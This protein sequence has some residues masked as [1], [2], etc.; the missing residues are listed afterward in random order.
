MTTKPV[1]RAAA[2]ALALGSLGTA[3]AA[4]T[5][6]AGQRVVFVS[7]PMI[8]NTYVP[9]WL[10]QDRGQLYY[11][12]PQG[13]LQAEFY[14]PQFG[15]R[16]L[17]EGQLA[18][19][20]DVCGA[21]P[22]KNVKASVLPDLDPSCNVILPAAGYP[23]PPNHRGPG[24]SGVKGGAPEERPRRGP[25]EAPKPPF[26]VQ[27]FTAT[28]DADSDR[29]WRPATQAINQ[30]FR[31]AQASNASRVEI[32]GYRAAIRLSNGQDFVEKDSIAE[33]RAKTA[34]EAFRVLGIPATTKLD[35]KWQAKP[36]PSTG[37]EKDAQSRK[38]V[39]RV[40]PGPQ[41]APTRTA[42]N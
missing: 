17:V 30:A 16:M 15:H 41:P 28:F 20:P 8:R 4:E 38:V 21:K 40:V 3:H 29:K 26:A 10:G 42:S 23:D 27:E 19:G 9:C 37:T 36:L 32:M 1:F 6:A 5:A 31:Y 24:P 18:D 13:D 11:I 33:A 39:I 14:P 25:P 12:G 7:C 34:E 2:L 22:L 35:V